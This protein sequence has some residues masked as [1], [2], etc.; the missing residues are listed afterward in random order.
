MIYNP[1]VFIAPALPAQMGSEA[2]AELYRIEEVCRAN[3][4][5][6]I[7]P[8]LSTIGTI[9]EYFGDNRQEQNTVNQELERFRPLIGRMG[10]VVILNG[11]TE[12][13][14]GELGG[15][16]LCRVPNSIGRFAAGIIGFANETFG[17]NSGRVFVSE[18][19]DLEDLDALKSS[20]KAV[21]KARER[22]GGVSKDKLTASG[23]VALN[24]VYDQM[25]RKAKTPPGTE[26]TQ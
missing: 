10:A 13:I 3:N 14:I 8:E 1:S 5:R 6:P 11:A 12:E 19:P 24:G 9:S 22:L 7:H 17:E 2:H 18:Y 25:I 4:I 20:R 15:K 16:V 21:L 23:V 26:T